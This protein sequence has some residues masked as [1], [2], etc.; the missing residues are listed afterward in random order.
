M[1]YF[2]SDTHFGHEAIIK[3][4][5]RPFN[6]VQEMDCY[7]IDRWRETISNNDKVY[8]LGDMFYRCKDVSSI[9]KLLPGQKHLLVGNHDKSWLHGNEGYFAS[10]N[11]VNTVV[12]N[13]GNVTMCHYPWV[14]WPSQNRSYMLHGHIHNDTN[15]PFYSYLRGNPRILNASVEVNGYRPCTIEEILS[16][17]M[18]FKFM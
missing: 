15:L 2:I 13:K 9:L 8:I 4:C 17:N 7:M 6:S 11:M 10:I 5:N 3:L 18:I 1:L 14:S 12:T 16:N